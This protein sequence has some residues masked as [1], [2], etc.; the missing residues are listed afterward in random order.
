VLEKGIAMNRALQPGNAKRTML[1]ESV[2]DDVPACK[3]YLEE[4]CSLLV[5][6]LSE[7]LRLVNPDDRYAHTL[8]LF[9]AIC[10]RAA[11]Q[12]VE[13]VEAQNKHTDVK[14]VNLPLLAC[15]VWSGLGMRWSELVDYCCCF[16]LLC[17]TLL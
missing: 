12:G 17:M 13:T 8:T 2:F 4:I 15:E 6:C 5:P 14:K 16:L 7:A 11:Q 9:V 10:Q 1:S 3:L